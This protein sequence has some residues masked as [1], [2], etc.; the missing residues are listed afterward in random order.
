MATN[1]GGAGE[2]VFTNAQ[3]MIGTV[4]YMRDE[5]NV[6]MHGGAGLQPGPLHDL[7]LDLAKRVNMV[8]QM[9]GMKGPFDDTES[10]ANSE[11][12]NKQM[13]QALTDFTNTAFGAQREAAQTIQT[14]ARGV[15][16]LD[17]TYAG[18]MLVLN[19]IEAQ[20]QR[21]I[22]MRGYQQQWMNRNQGYLNGSDVAF[23]RAFPYTSYVDKAM[24]N[25]FPSFTAL[26][27]AVIDGQMTKDQA[28][29]IAGHLPP[30]RRR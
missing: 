10:I 23:N 14:M 27:Q 30:E 29:I 3:R 13:V 28:E 19:S 21:I 5:L 1:F 6:I 2:K 17:N 18:N 12:F 7:R 4:Q 24:G 16:G 9:F 26:K 11:A 22:D 25:A 15:P 20:A 8:H